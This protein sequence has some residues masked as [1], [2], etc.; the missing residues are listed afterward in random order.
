MEETTRRRPRGMEVAGA[1]LPLTNTSC[2]FADH[3][4][5]PAAGDGGS[6]GV[7]RRCVAPDVG[8]LRSGPVLP[9]PQRLSAGKGMRRGGAALRCAL[10]DLWGQCWRMVGLSEVLFKNKTGRKA[11]K[12]LGF[13]RLALCLWPTTEVRISCKISRSM[14][15]KLERD[16]WLQSC[17]WPSSGV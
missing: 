2:M 10:S 7:G 5:P 3:Q 11:T 4:R 15:P 13:S 17:G 16:G 1:H 12:P 9:K 6:V 8:L 14:Q